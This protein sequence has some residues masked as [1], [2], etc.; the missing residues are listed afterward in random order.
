MYS[1]PLLTLLII[2][3]NASL[4]WPGQGPSPAELKAGSA[5]PELR[6]AKLLQAPEGEKADWGHLKGNVVVLEFWATWCAPCIAAMP[7]LNE[8]AEKFKDKP[9][10]FIA[11]TNEDEAIVTSFIGRRVMKSW[12]GIDSARTTM[13]SYD[14]RY[15]PYTI[16]IGRDGKIAAITSPK[17]LTQEMISELVEGRPAVITRQ[18]EKDVTA[19]AQ[20]AA[21]QQG[22][23]PRFTLTITPSAS[24]HSSSVVGTGVIEANGVDLK[25]ALSLVY[26]LPKSRV[27]GPASLEE[28]RYDVKASMKEGDKNDLKPI[29]ARTLEASF[30][31]R[32]RRETREMEV[33][34]LTVAERSPVRIRPASSKDWHSS[35]DEGVLAASGA[36]IQA[37]VQGIESKLNQPVVDETNL[38]GKYDW[39]VIFDGKR[40]ESIIEALHKDLGLV[41]QRAKRPVEVLV[42]EM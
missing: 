3:L 18:G 34:V 14:V 35:S 17:R 30:G 36:S 19:I 42:A 2:V 16:V 23:Q 5:A 7:H 28:A 20:K 9:V 4:A 39:D 13:K 22:P 37:L 33:Y 24:E 12:V 38:K 31:L 15:F 6:L 10:R 25:T 27:F 8:L 32:V 40:P 41:L 11:I 1:R 29:L 26:D 21:G